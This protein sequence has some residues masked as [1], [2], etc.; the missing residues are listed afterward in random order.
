MVLLVNAQNLVSMNTPDSIDDLRAACSSL[1]CSLLN[2]GT[3]DA[4]LD[5][6]QP[7]MSSRQNLSVDGESL[8]VG[9]RK[10]LNAT[11]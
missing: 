7:V 4:M 8:V 9:E 5:I 10:L 6:G 1:S 3:G 11:R 2:D